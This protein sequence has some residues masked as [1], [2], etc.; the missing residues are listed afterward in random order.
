MKAKGEPGSPELKTP[1]DNLTWNDQDNSGLPNG[2]NV[3]IA[4]IDRIEVVTIVINN[5]GLDRINFQEL[6]EPY[7]YY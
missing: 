1:A 4:M 5:S 3:Q 7:Y 6:S 2:R